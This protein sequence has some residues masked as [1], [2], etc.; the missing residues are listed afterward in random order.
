M[1]SVEFLCETVLMDELV[2]IEKL[3]KL[4]ESFDR[5]NVREF[6][7]TIRNA[8]KGT[9]PAI[10]SWLQRFA[11]ESQTVISSLSEE[12]IRFMETFW[13]NIVDIDEPVETWSSL[14]LCKLCDRY[15]NM[16]YTLREACE[17]VQIMEIRESCPFMYEKAL[18][19]FERMFKKKS[20]G[21]I[22][23]KYSRRFYTCLDLY[24]VM[25]LWIASDYV[26][27][28]AGEA[29]KP[30]LIMRKASM[31]IREILEDANEHGFT[32]LH[33]VLCKNA[34]DTLTN[35]AV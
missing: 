18:I 23:N 32:M 21:S 33:K 4:L 9:S 35:F 31:E 30:R 16:V 1:S 29:P 6:V 11:D 22:V 27:K 3:V 17:A 19:D 12:E 13:D 8:M 25:M 20:I 2:E 15:M 10:Q 14:Q 28:L 5:S 24:S 7:D 26:D 34:I